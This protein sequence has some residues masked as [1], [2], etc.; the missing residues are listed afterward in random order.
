M[1]PS[2][3]RLD[4]DGMSAKP[5]PAE[6]AIGPLLLRA[7]R[8]AADAFNDALEPLGIQGRHFGVLMTLRSL[9]PMSQQ[10][11]TTQLGSD[12]SSMV[13]LIDDLEGRGLLERR[14]DASDRRAF[15]VTLTVEGESLFGR[16]QRAAV[17]VS[18]MLL[19]DLTPAERRELPRLLALFVGAD[20]T[21]RHPLPEKNG[22][23]SDERG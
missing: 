9:G 2:W 20:P 16:A 22:H 6:L 19:A 1:K 14:P 18:R 7:H 13:R 3:V 8:R 15:A 11:L 12:K 23:R 10:R 4:C 5:F 17:G 21:D